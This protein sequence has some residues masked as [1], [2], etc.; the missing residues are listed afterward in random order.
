MLT[1]TYIVILIIVL[2][3]ALGAAV[4][5]GSSDDSTGIST[6][7]QSNIFMENRFN[8]RQNEFSWADATVMPGFHYPGRHFSYHPGNHFPYQSGPNHPG[9][10]PGNH[11]GNHPSHVNRQR[12]RSRHRQRRTNHM[13]AANTTRGM[14]RVVETRIVNGIP[15]TY[16]RFEGN[17][18]S[19][20][21][22]EGMIN[23]VLDVFNERDDVEAGVLTLVQQIGDFMFGDVQFENIPMEEQRNNDIPANDRA[24]IANF[25]S[26]GVPGLRVETFLNMSVVDNNDAENVHDTSVNAAMAAIIK[27]LRYDQRFLGLPA[28]GEIRYNILENAN[29]YSSGR[30]ELVSMALKPLRQPSNEMIVAIGASEIEIIQRIWLRSSDPKN[31]KVKKEM[32]QAFFD[33]AVDCNGRNGLV[34]MNGRSAR[35]IASLTLLD[36]DQRNWDIR[37]SEQ[38]KNE[39]FEEIKKVIRSEAEKTAT[40][41]DDD[42]SRKVARSYL[43]T[44]QE[45][46]NEIGDVD[47]SYVESFKEYLKEKITIKVEEVVNAINSRSPGAIS[48]E[49]KR[50]VIDEAFMT[51]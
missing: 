26:E 21:E 22:T 10:H 43:A 37:K 41:A 33:A 3:F 19:Q 38:Y 2:F 40:I 5:I 35:F 11:P 39:I 24:E 23:F 18:N 16:I 1:T 30:K 4:S 14:D 17:A 48:D 27:R 49:S 51:L 6:V 42:E 47:E 36:H 50:K 28:I 44:T 7:S 45:E 29:E 8:D 46:M 32:R 12:D 31:S 13:T 25:V 20:E 15:A 34:C 9:G